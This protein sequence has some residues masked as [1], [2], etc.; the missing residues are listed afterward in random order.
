VFENREPRRIY[1]ARKEKMAGGGKKLYAVQLRKLY[2]S[3]STIRKIKS[4]MIRWAEHVAR[5]ER[6]GTLVDY[7]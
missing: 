4:M 3:P 6:R 2:F 5:M 1:G 7:W